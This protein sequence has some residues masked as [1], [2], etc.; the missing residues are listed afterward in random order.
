ML[1]IPIGHENS[2][3]NRFPVVSTAIVVLCVV[4]F[5]QTWPRC[6]TEQA[7]IGELLTSIFY[8]ASALIPEGREE[9]EDEE[10]AMQAAM[11]AR[12]PVEF[13]DTLEK[14]LESRSRSASASDRE[15]LA[16]LAQD[17]QR[18]RLLLAGGVFFR[19]GLVPSS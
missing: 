6:Q 1:L 19:Y 18:A 3:V 5:G 15:Q 12:G 8:R 10:S 4:A 14:S 9:A 16:D 2:R 17:I 11:R 7:E 13:L